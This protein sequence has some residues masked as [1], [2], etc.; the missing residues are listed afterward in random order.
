MINFPFPLSAKAFWICLM[1]PTLPKSETTSKLIAIPTSTNSVRN[2]LQLG[3]TRFPLARTTQ[4]RYP[5]I[6]IGFAAIGFTDPNK[7]QELATKM[8][9]QYK[10]G[11]GELIWA[12][13]MCRPDIAFTS[14]KLSQ[15]N[16]AP[17][18]HHYHGLK[19]AIWCVYITRY[20]GLYFW[21]TQ[22]CEELPVCPLPVV[23]SNKQD[24][25]LDDHQNH[26]SCTAV[27]YSDSD[28]ATCVKICCLFG[29]ICIQLVGGIIAH[30]TKF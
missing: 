14:V 16:S 2:T 15:S 10:G 9:I 25:L 30:K 18:E 24:L 20:D 23:N 27:P 29:S 8:Q 6:L 7:Q 12:M 4:P 21:Q 28:W 5:L 19:H 13:T 17:A 3:S 11:I 1:A 22:P 26:N